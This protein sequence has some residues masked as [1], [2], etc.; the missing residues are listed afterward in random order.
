MLRII[1]NLSMNS[2]SIIKKFKCELFNLENET[3]FIQYLRVAKVLYIF[4]FI[5]RS[6]FLTWDHC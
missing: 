6:L 2:N 1:S 5:H 4:E 3:T